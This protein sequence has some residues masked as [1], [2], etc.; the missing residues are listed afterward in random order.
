MIARCSEKPAKPLQRP[1]GGMADAEDLKAEAL[2]SKA[3]SIRNHVAESP[4][5]KPLCDSDGQS[6]GDKDAVEIALADALTKASSAGQWDVVALLSRELEARRKA[7]SGV[8]ELAA[9][10][11]NG[12]AK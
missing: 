11:K 12:G 7:R 3:P 9:F 2:C 5:I 10:R 8:V 6:L 1:L 4:E